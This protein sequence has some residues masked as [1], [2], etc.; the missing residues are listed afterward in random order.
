M[1]FPTTCAGQKPPPLDDPNI[2]PDIRAWWKAN[3]NVDAQKTMPNF[4]TL[5][6]NFMARQERREAGIRQVEEIRALN[7][8]RVRAS[9]TTPPIAEQKEHNV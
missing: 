5:S 3:M 2:A 4:P 8:A 9:S 1:P 7:K 6:N